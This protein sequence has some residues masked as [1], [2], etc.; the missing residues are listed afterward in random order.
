MD[1]NRDDLVY[2]LDRLIK[3]LPDDDLWLILDFTAKLI[4]V[5]HIPIEPS[6]LD[7]KV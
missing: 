1:T 5:K 6:D 7:R 3:L 4:A 2:A